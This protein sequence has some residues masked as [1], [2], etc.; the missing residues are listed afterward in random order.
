MLAEY[1]RNQE[2]S[3]D[4]AL[5]GGNTKLDIDVERLD[6]AFSDVLDLAALRRKDSGIRCGPKAAFLGE[7]KH[8]FPDKV[9]RGVVVPFGA[10]HAHY[11]SAPVAIPKALSGKG[12]ARAGEPL[13]SFVE[14]TYDEFFGSLVPNGADERALAAWVQPRLEIM[15]HSLQ[16]HPL[17][18][19][20][21]EGIRADLERQ[22]L[23]EPGNPEQTVGLFVR[24]DTNVEDLDNFNGA[25]LNLTLFNRQSLQDVYAG[26][27]EVW[28]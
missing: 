20:L 9:A 26:L 25:G 13:P 24:S 6:V 10:Y 4:G 16:Q 12:L 21:R 28:A 5:G 7:L 1:T 15:R 3:G 8:R 2:R 19:E 22:G 11:R 14:A 17:S 23:L 27:K 18:P